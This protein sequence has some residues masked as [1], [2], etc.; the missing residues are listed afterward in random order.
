[1][2]EIEIYIDD[3]QIDT[4]N[5]RVTLKLQLIELRDFTKRKAFKTSTIE[6]PATATNQRVFGYLEDVGVRYPDERMTGYVSAGALTFRGYVRLYGSKTVNGVSVYRFQFIAANWLEELRGVR[7]SDLDWSDDD[8]T[9]TASEITAAESLTSRSYIYPLLDYGAFHDNDNVMAVERF[10]AIRVNAIID[11][12]LKRVGYKAHPDSYFTQ[13]ANQRYFM[14]SFEKLLYNDGDFA[15]NRLFKVSA[16]DSDSQTI[17]DGSIDEAL[18]LDHVIG[19]DTDSGS[20]DL[21]IDTDNYSKTNKRYTADKAGAY[22]FQASVA[23]SWSSSFLTNIDFDIDVKIK[24][25]GVT[26]GTASADNN[27]S[28]TGSGTI[29]IDTSFIH[30]SASDYIEVWVT[31]DGDVDNDSGQ[32]RTFT[33]SVTS[34][35]RFWND[36]D[37]RRG[38]GFPL[39]FADVVPDIDVITFLQG[40]NHVFNLWYYVNQHEREV[41]MVPGGE[42]YETTAIDWSSKLDTSKAV[43][44]SLYDAP[45]ALR[46]Q[47]ADD[48]KDSVVKGKPGYGMSEYTFSDSQSDV[49]TVSNRVFARTWLNYCRRIGLESEYMLPV[50]WQELQKGKY[51]TEETEAGA[52][53]PAWTGEF[54]ARLL[55]YGGRR[56]LS[57]DAW[58]FEGTSQTHVVE[59]NEDDIEP[60]D[61]RDR[62]DVMQRNMGVSKVVDAYFRLTSADVA[63]I[64]SMTGDADMRYPVRVETDELQGVF[65]IISVTGYDVS[66]ERPAKVRLLQV[67]DKTI[68]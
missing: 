56:S 62:Y 14:V 34:S 67:N 63:D 31:L 57:A 55:H 37:P 9:V 20:D 19:F 25:N 50:M 24:K 68:K 48:G 4:G 60:D 2:N 33:F 11:K 12:A 7:L 39:T 49:E 30:L 40:I 21:F 23:Y 6:V 10:P 8:H 58:T 53:V 44:V 29:T 28:G 16:A 65:Y 32:D 51:S 41:L 35:S 47:Y 15:T 66:S 42:F 27:T 46:Y 1:M 54:K 45:A 52:Y 61:I 18:T 5:V 22:R 64:L 26:I 59:L 36:A 3:K 13:L 17:P 43:T 38:L